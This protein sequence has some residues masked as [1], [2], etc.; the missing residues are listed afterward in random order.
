MAVNEAVV[1]ENI[2]QILSDASTLNEMLVYSLSYSDNIICLSVGNCRYA[3]S[4]SEQYVMEKLNGFVPSIVTWCHEYLHNEA[5][6]TNKG[7][8]MEVREFWNQS[9]SNSKA[10]VGVSVSSVRDIEENVWCPR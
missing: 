10:Q 5:G 4:L 6:R 7:G 2:T 3:L 1:R 8:R 9:C